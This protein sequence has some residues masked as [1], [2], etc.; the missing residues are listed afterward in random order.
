MSTPNS[1]LP[2]PNVSLFEE[3]SLGVGGWE[4]EVIGFFDTLWSPHDR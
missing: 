3:I 4:L 2:T 1:E